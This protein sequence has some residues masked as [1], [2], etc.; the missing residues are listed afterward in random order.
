MVLSRS[1]ILAARLLGQLASRLHSLSAMS[2]NSKSDGLLG[3]AIFPQAQS[4]QTP[5]QQN[6]AEIH[7]RIQEWSERQG[8]P[9]KGEPGGKV[10]KVQMW[11]DAPEKIAKHRELAIAAAPGQV[12]D[13]NSVESVQIE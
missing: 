11:S 5:E 6:A 12:Y 9:E 8:A 10:G 7:G 3:A 13:L 1:E 2:L 4:N